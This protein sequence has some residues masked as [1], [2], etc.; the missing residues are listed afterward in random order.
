MARKFCTHDNFIFPSREN[1]AITSK[2]FA[3]LAGSINLSKRTHGMRHIVIYQVGI[4][5]RG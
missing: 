1:F 4:D 5:H 3:I 2:A